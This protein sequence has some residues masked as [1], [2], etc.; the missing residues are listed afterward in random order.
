M[1]KE[2]FT[3]NISDETLAQLIDETVRFE[4]NNK[5]NKR[6][7]VLFKIIPVAAMIALVIGAVNI[8]PAVLKINLSGDGDGT[9]GALATRTDIPSPTEINYL[10]EKEIELFLPQIIEKSFFENRVLAA[11]SDEFDKKTVNTYYRLTELSLPYSAELI[12]DGVWSTYTFEDDNT[13]QFYKLD[14]QMTDRET[15]ELFAILSEAGFTGNDM[16]RMYMNAGASLEEIDDPYAH[17]RFGKTRDILLLDIEWHTYETWMEM[18]VLE[19]IEVS[20]IIEQ[21]GG[22]DAYIQEYLDR[23]RI[24]N[25]VY[26]A[27]LDLEQVYAITEEIKGFTSDFVESL[28]PEEL[29]AYI[30]YLKTIDPEFF[31]PADAIKAKTRYVPRTINGKD[32]YESEI[33]YNSGKSLIIDNGTGP[34]DLFNAGYI[35]SDGYFIYNVYPQWI[36]ICDLENF[37]SENHQCVDS[38]DRQVKTKEE[39]MRIYEN[40]L[41]PH[42]DDLLAIGV[43]DQEQYDWYTRLK[44]DPLDY[45]VNLFF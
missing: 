20:K 19:L 24:S 21:T 13:N 16:M 33:L 23:I 39:Y 11:V 32:V 40:E 26:A 1:N 41:V 37:D 22:T 30:E 43:I 45:Y 17:V 31:E 7:P 14:S 6:I 3:E 18:I 4:K 25:P 42:Y 27:R 8:L 15:N 28:E 44:T 9:P 10:N 2:Y 35:D 12:A 5:D 34:I 29:M 38:I 36:H